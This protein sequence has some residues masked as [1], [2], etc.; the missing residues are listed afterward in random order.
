MLLMKESRREEE[1]RYKYEK[2]KLALV[3][4]LAGPQVA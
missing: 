2:E 1:M 3:V 4:N